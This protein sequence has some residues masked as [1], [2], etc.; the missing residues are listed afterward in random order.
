MSWR[1]ILGHDHQVQAFAQARRRGRLAHAYLFT[2]PPGIGKHLF[3]HELAKAVLCENPPPDCL[4]ACDQCSSCVLVE[5][6]TH[7]DYAHAQ[8]PAESLDVPIDTIRALCQ[9]FSLKSARGQGKV[10]ILD[11]ADDLNVAAAN[12]FLKTLEEPP[13]RSVLI[14]IG[15]SADLQLPTIVSRCQVIHFRPLPADLV[16]EL[17]RRQD[18]TDDDLLQ[19][20]TRLSGGSP[21]QALALADPALWDFRQKL[22][23]GL[24]RPRPDATALAHDFMKFV[25]EAGKESSAQRR[26]A[27]LV[28]RLLIDFLRHALALSVEGTPPVEPEEWESLANLAHRLG[29]E[30]LLD[31]LQRC[32]DADMHIDRRVQLV[33]AVEALVDN[34]GKVLARA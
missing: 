32:L 30:R 28:L 15:T 20:L 27:S 9:T 18:V 24:T 4:E 22:I 8:R 21:G 10:A 29:P 33:L 5:A 13:P 12:C 11:D 19:R 2:G 26:R 7:P 1:R 25:E 14:L 17:L 34:L 3:A 31:V 16:A 23:A 6:G